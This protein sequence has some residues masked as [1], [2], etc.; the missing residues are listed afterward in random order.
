LSRILVL[1]L[2]FLVQLF[3]LAEPVNNGSI[4]IVKNNEQD[5]SASFSLD[6][7]PGCYIKKSELCTYQNSRKSCGDAFNDYLY[8]ERVG[9]SYLVRLNSTQANQNA[10]YFSF[11]MERFGENLIHET[12]Y[13][14]ISLSYK[15]GRL[16]L[17]SKGI[18]PTALGIG[19]CGVHAD[20]DQLAFPIS[21]RAN[22]S[23]YCSPDRN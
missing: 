13:G 1:V 8:V 21:S 7:W 16:I 11:E 20:I 15:K 9:R 18:D 2:S 5:Y 6:K 19:V 4:S 22:S 3:C 12:Q 10:C 23:E 17:S 14:R